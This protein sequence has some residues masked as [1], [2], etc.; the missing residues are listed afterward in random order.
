MQ[1]TPFPAHYQFVY[2]NFDFSS[3]SRISC[4]AKPYLSPRNSLPFV[5]RK[6]IIQQTQL[7]IQDSAGR[8]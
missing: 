1:I 5:R 8:E 4:L 2:T 3:F 7:D 6:L